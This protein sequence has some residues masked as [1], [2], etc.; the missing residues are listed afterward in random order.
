MTSTEVKVILTYERMNR[1]KAQM[2]FIS[3]ATSSESM[4]GSGGGEEALI[5][6]SN[7]SFKLSSASQSSAT[8]VG[9]EKFITKHRERAWLPHSKER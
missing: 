7:I 4:A 3:Y 8:L 2:S 6:E 5:T 9:S 1:K